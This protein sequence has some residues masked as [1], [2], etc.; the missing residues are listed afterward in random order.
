MEKEII[1]RMDIKE[2]REQGFLFEANRKFFHPLGLALEIIINE[3]DNSEILGGVWDYRDDPEGIF[4]GMNNLI[5]RAK[6]IDTIEE[7]RKSKLQNRVNHKEFK[8]NKNGIQEF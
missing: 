4:F 6:K 3:E 1:K 7:L 5:D 2:F 8:C